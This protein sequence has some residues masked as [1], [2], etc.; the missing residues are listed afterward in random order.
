MNF[1]KI[2]NK[3]KKNKKKRII[4]INTKTEHSTNLF[5]G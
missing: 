5:E 1:V 4:T 2:I 3:R